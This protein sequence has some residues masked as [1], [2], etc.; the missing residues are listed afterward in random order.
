MSLRVSSTNVYQPDSTPA[1]TGNDVNCWW[2]DR[3]KHTCA[4]FG[5][6]AMYAGLGLGLGLGFTP[7]LT[8]RPNPKPYPRPSPNRLQV[9]SLCRSAGYVHERPV[10]QRSLHEK[11]RYGVLGLG[12]GLGLGSE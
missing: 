10:A 7:T 3:S 8:P 11:H 4:D 5:H 6:L 2:L 9:R 1:N 12:L